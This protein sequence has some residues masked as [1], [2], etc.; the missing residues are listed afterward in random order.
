MTGSRSAR[1]GL[2]GIVS[3]E[4]DKLQVCLTQGGSMEQPRPR[5]FAPDRDCAPCCLRS[6]RDP[7]GPPREKGRNRGTRRPRLHRR[8][9]EVRA[10]LEHDDASHVVVVEFRGYGA[11]ITDD[12][13]LVPLADCTIW[14]ALTPPSGTS[15]LR[16][17]PLPAVVP[18]FP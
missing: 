7:Q 11:G 18:W 13:D 6:P 5:R 4:G 10:H 2:P 16:G 12:R 8:P 17:S 9:E 1:P 15:P 3:L 14:N